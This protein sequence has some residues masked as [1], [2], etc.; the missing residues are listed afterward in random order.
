MSLPPSPPAFLGLYLYWKLAPPQLFLVSLPRNFKINGRLFVVEPLFSKVAGEIYAFCNSAKK[1]I[2]FIGMFRNV[3]L[4][5]ILKS[6]LLIGIYGLES[7]TCNASKNKLLTKFLQGILKIS[8]N[9]KKRSVT[10]LL[11]NKLWTC[12]LQQPSVF[13]AFEIWEISLNNVCCRVPFY[14]NRH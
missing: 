10:D 13:P 5:E 14:R 3:A 7:R 12:K 9:F 11:F 4:L 2:T 1:S 8:E 6:C